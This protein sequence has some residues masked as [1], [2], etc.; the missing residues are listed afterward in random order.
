MTAA[1]RK[2][3]FA[4][5]GFLALAWPSAGEDPGPENDYRRDSIRGGT[6]MMSLNAP[7]ERM[8]PWI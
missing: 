5:L 6:I 2:T 7:A 1:S 8:P 3:P 4:V